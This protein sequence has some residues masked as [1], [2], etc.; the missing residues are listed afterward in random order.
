MIGGLINGLGL[1]LIGTAVWGMVGTSAAPSDALLEV[2]L[3]FR[4]AG[5]A[6]AG[7]PAMAAAYLHLT[8]AAI[9]RATSALYS[10]QRLGGSVGTAALAVILASRLSTAVGA[11]DVSAA[12]GWTFRWSILMTGLAIIPALMLPSRRLTENPETAEAALAVSLPV[13]EV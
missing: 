11:H 7:V 2:A 4:G 12:F 6:S 5:I 1:T 13:A 9:P 3:F 10:L 8:H